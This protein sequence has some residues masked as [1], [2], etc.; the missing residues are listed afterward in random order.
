MSQ[1]MKTEVKNLWHSFHTIA[2]RKG[3]IFTKKN[4]DYLQKNADISKIKRTLVLKDLFCESV[5]TYVPN[6]KFL[7]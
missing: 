7:V 3:T 1:K 6:F 2:M 4:A 5:F